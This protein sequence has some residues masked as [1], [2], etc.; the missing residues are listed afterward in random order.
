[1]RWSFR[2]KDAGSA[3]SS[4]IEATEDAASGRAA[5]PGGTAAFRQTLLVGL[6][7]DLS[8]LVSGKPACDIETELAL[9]LLARGRRHLDEESG[10]TDVLHV[11]ARAAERLPELGGE[12]GGTDQDAK[13]ADR[14]W[15]T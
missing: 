5:R 1:M 11:A 7:V 6:D 8:A 2:G 12:F 10:L 14:D 15:T 9:G 3:D 4:A 13:G